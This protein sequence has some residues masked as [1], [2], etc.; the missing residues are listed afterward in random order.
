[1]PDYG[2]QDAVFHVIE[3]VVLRLARNENIRPVCDSVVNQEGSAPPAY[4]HLAD[5]I[6]RQSRIQEQGKGLR[7][8]PLAVGRNLFHRA[9]IRAQPE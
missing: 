2:Q 7:A 8:R 4:R 1:M 9:R 6:A 5:R 3:V